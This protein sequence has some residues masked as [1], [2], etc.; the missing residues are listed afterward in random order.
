[1]YCVENVTTCCKTPF[2]YKNKKKNKCL[3]KG[4]KLACCRL[5]RCHSFDRM[6]KFYALYS[7]SVMCS[8]VY[9]IV[10]IIQH[11]AG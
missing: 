1:M 9:C 8:G 11:C 2:V 6:T 5:F 3:L 7:K 4:E 10:F